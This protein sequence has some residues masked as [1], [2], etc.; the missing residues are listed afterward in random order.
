MAAVSVVLYASLVASGL[1]RLQH[2]LLATG[3]P[4]P[5]KGAYSAQQWPMQRSTTYD[6]AVVLGHALDRNG[7]PSRVLAERIDRA[8]DLFNRG[9]VK[10]VLF[11]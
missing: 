6:V 10:H 7:R 2:A 3:K 9:V 8:V 1:S 4:I 5:N 11:R